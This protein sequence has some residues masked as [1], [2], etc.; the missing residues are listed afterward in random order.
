MFKLMGTEIFTILCSEMAKLVQT[1][2][3]VTHGLTK[4]YTASSIREA[5]LRHLLHAHA[6]VFRCVWGGG[7][8]GSLS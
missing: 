8:G 6:I 2:P 5:K 7:G 4:M 1:Q 3:R